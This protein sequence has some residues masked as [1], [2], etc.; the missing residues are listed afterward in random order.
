MTHSHVLRISSQGGL[1]PLGGADDGEVEDYAV[2]IF[3]E[4]P[5]RD[6]GDAPGTSYG[7]ARADSGPSHILGGPQLG[8]SVDAE[9][10]GS[11]SDMATGDGADEDGILFN[12]YC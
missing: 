9:T 5:P 7:T 2:T 6:F 11:T 4:D 1:G 8:A 12:S 10:D 3:A